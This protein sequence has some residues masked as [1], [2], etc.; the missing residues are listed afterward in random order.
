MPYVDGSIAAVPKKNLAAY[1]CLSNKAGKVW[2]DMARPTIANGS[3][4]TSS[5][6]SS[7]R[8]ARA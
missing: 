4:T 8:F 5:P 6:A 2:R 7:R 3:P 1:T